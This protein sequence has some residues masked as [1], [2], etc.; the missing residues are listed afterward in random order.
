MCINSITVNNRFEV[1][2][3]QV[4]TEITDMGIRY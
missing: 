2:V 1:S 4:P 3:S